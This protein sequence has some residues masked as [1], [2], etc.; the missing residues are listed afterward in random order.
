MDYKAK[1]QIHDS[2]RKNAQSAFPEYWF[3]RAIK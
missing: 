3:I 2:Y 1:Q